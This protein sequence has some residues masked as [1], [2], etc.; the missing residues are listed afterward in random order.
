MFFVGGEMALPEG[1]FCVGGKELPG[2]VCTQVWE[3]EPPEGGSF[4]AAG[5]RKR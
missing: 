3:K 4:Y 2:A 5:V 1:C